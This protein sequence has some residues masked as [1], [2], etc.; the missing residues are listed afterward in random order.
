LA[1]PPAREVPTVTPSSPEPEPVSA[2]PVSEIP[3]PAPVPEHQQPRFTP[4]GSPF[5][6]KLQQAWRKD[7]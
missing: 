4:S 2:A 3:P 6:E 5:A 1:D 7:S